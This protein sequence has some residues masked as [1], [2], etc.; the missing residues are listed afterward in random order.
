MK[1][2]L[3]VLF[4]YNPADSDGASLIATEQIAS[5]SKIHDLSVINVIEDPLLEDIKIS[6]DDIDYQTITSDK[7]PVIKFKTF[8]IAYYSSYKLLNFITTIPAHT[9]IFQVNNLEFLKVDTFLQT[10]TTDLAKKAEITSAYYN[11]IKETDLTV[12][13]SKKDMEYFQVLKMVR[14]DDTVITPF[15]QNIP[16]HSLVSRVPYLA[17]ISAN[18][19]NPTNRQSLKW[20]LKE[21]FPLL[22]SKIKLNITGQGSLEQELVRPSINYLGLITK[23]KLQELYNTSSVFINPTISQSGF[24]LKVLEALSNNLPV[25]ST[26]SGNTFQHLIKSSDNPLELANLI[27]DALVDNK[28]TFNFA[29]FNEANM[30][31]FI[32]LFV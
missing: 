26:D 9:K 32:G 15:M 11:C 31:R 7:L 18:L 21:V 1:S 30:N 4:N 23:E 29:P 5:L 22:N 24:Q 2:V 16:T 10:N 3:F 8:D 20:F 13:L 25:I 27:N 19:N 6:L 12:Y 17:L 14:K 28:S